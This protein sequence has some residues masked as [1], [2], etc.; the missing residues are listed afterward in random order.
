MDLSPLIKLS[1]AT[2][3]ER[4]KTIDIFDIRKIT[5]KKA[6][7]TAKINGVIVDAHIDVWE[8]LKRT[9]E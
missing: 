4:F 2:E 6:F 5:E 8:I 7:F 1:V 3:N 9:M